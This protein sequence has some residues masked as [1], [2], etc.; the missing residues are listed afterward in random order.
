MYLS[1]LELYIALVAELLVRTPGATFG[2]VATL[3]SAVVLIP[4]GL[5]FFTRLTKKWQA[6]V[7]HPAT[8]AWE[9]DNLKRAA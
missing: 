8:I 3:S 9:D 5:L 7:R 2:R 1:V 4:G 6:R